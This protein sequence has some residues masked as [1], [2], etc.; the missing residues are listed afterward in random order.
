VLV[1]GEPDEAGRHA[2]ARGVRLPDDDRPVL[3][4]RWQFERGVLELELA[5]GRSRVVRRLCAELGLGVRQ[6]VRVSYGPVA[7]RDLAPGRS[8]TPTPSERDALYRAVQLEPPQD[9][10]W[11]SR[12]PRS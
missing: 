10:S 3:P 6:L 1:T 11:I 8:R 4:L 2:L 7:L 5:E 9:T 12:T